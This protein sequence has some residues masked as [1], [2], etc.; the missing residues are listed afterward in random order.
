MP[1]KDSWQ[2]AQK[3]VEQAIGEHARNGSWPERSRLE[4]DRIGG[5]IGTESGCCMR[6]KILM[7]VA[8]F[9]V[10]WT[11]LVHLPSHWNPVLAYPLYLGLVFHSFVVGQHQT[12]T[13]DKIGFAAELAANLAIYLTATLAIPT[14]FIR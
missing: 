4:L 3:V 14:R 11:L 13:W 7:G 10:I 12:L 1:K 6:T 5:I 8:A 9:V 2:I